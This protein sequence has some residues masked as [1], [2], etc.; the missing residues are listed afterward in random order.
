VDQASLFSGVHMKIETSTFSV[1]VKM[2]L[3]C[4]AV[5]GLT[6]ACSM[7]IHGAATDKAT[8]RTTTVFSRRLKTIIH[9]A[10]QQLMASC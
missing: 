4:T 10:Q 5:L 1:D 7:H 6:E 3:S 2:R 8:N 9:T